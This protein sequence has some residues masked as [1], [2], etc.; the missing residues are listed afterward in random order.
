MKAKFFFFRILF[1][2]LIFY[3]TLSQHI[4]IFEH[5]DHPVCEESAIHFHEGD[6][7][8]PLLDYVSNTSFALLETFINSTSID[9]YEQEKSLHNFT[10]YSKAL[11]AKTLR[12]PPAA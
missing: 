3:P 9:G 2:G 5:H 1:A 12:G 7:S 6:T 10:V 11:F 4:H 8:C